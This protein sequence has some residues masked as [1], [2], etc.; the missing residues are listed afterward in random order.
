MSWVDRQFAAQ[1]AFT[2]A[3]PT[4]K[5]AETRQC[6]GPALHWKKPGEGEGKVCLD[7]HGRATIKFEHVPKGRGQ[8]GRDGDVGRWLVPRGLRRVRR[9]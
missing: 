9:G 7:D 3:F 4:L 6:F 8:P 1:E 2:A 5:P